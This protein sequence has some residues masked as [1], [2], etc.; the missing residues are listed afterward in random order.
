[1][2][3]A[4]SSDMAALD[5]IKN[6]LLGEFSPICKTSG[7]SVVTELQTT[8]IT[9]SSSSSSSSSDISRSQSTSQSSIEIS[10]YF[11]NELFDFTS[12]NIP[13]PD[14][15][16]EFET[17]PQ[18]IDL[19]TPKPTD[20]TSQTSFEFDSK[21][22]FNSSASFFEFQPEVQ[23]LNQ[24]APKPVST[25]ARKPALTITLPNK[26]EWIQFSNSDK[27][28]LVVQKTV[29]NEEKKKHYRGVRQ[30]PWGK[31]AAEIRDPNRR[32]SRVWLGTF[33]AAIEAAKAY[34]RAAFKLRGSKA[35]LNF[36]LEAGKHDTPQP[37]KTAAVVERKRRREEEVKPEVPVVVKKEKV[38]DMP[39]TPSSWTAVLWDSDEDVKGIFCVPPLSPLSPHPAMGFSQLM[40]V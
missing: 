27:S 3:P 17:K 2:E 11:D 19:T 24:T 4:L 28:Q 22:Q 33:D 21:P 38:T 6:H 36:P 34:D 23:I 12:N 32:G 37:N 39:L 7:C 35:I 18:V 30:R 25:S 13:I 8:T 26:T 9:S 20:L 14:D 40:V 1:M 29:Q 16:F 31:Y 5:F 10:D 15:F